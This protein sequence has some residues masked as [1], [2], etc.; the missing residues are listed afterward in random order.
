MKTILFS[1]I[2]V[3]ITTEIHSQ[4]NQERYWFYRKRLRDYFLKIGDEAGA[5]IPCSDRNLWESRSVSFGD[6]TIE[7]GW[8]IG[9]L[10]GE[11]KLIS[12]S[13]DNIKN[14][15]LTLQELYYAL[16]AFQRIDECEGTAPW[17]LNLDYPH[18]P[19]I[20]NPTF[21]GFFNR[22]DLEIVKDTSLFDWQSRNK[23]LNSS[24]NDK[25]YTQPGMPYFANI[26]HFYEQMSI[27]D[28]NEA[29]SQD[30]VAHLYMGLAMVNK[31][32][33][34]N[35]IEVKL[36]DGTT[37][38][39]NFRDFAS[40]IAFKTL[41][42]MYNSNYYFSWLQTF[43][44]IRTPFGFPVERG[45]YAQA[46]AYGFVKAAAYITDGLSNTM[47]DC[48]LSG[49][50]LKNLFKAQAYYTSSPNEYNTTMAMALAAVGDS[51]SSLYGTVSTSFYLKHVGQSLRRHTFF[52]ALNKYLHNNNT[53]YYSASEY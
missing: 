7:L 36:L 25:R 39:F 2:L 27:Y 12:R 43:W 42:Y 44:V 21:D 29:M 32:L 24:I 46:N 10:A 45:A 52:I 20:N 38:L 19:I 3:L 53:I 28:R 22:S 13:S 37:I 41:R 15:E 4:S 11:Y 5:S 40:D 48:Y 51:W 31:C 23:N 33:P 35:D 14:T 17:V 30:Q 18:P 8:Y 47:L 9:V 1:I 50:T 26:Q 16:K 49:Q 34:D 6:A